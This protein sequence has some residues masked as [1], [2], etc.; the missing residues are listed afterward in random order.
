M[1]YFDVFWS[2]NIN[3][4]HHF[5]QTTFHEEKQDTMLTHIGSNGIIRSK[6]HNLNAKD[7]VQRITDTG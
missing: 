2:A 6:Q 7:V 5:I 4:L 1:M 3:R